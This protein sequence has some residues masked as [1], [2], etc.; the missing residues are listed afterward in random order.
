MDDLMAR[1]AWMEMDF[2]AIE[3]NLAVVRRCAGD[4]KAI[5]ASVKAN[6]YGHGV[7]E[8]AGRLVQSGVEVLATGSWSD[9]V[10]M[11]RAGLR[12]P[13]LMMG[14]ALPSA[15]PD[16][17]EW[18]LIPTVHNREL[19][20]AIK[21]NTRA[22]RR[23]YIK[24]DSG[25]GRLG[26]PLPD[27]H[28]FALQ[29]ARAPGLEIAGLYTHLPFFDAAGCKWARERLA[30]FD[31]LVAALARDGLEI[32]IT[33]SRASAALLA[34]LQGPMFGRISGRND[35]WSLPGRPRAG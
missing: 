23:I 11:R 24:V 4:G 1:P 32:P 30:Q 35:I 8:V 3:H 28:N 25:F 7:V 33:Q 15:I 31:A 16:M 27:A 2:S 26:V 13:I 10:R 19:A 17:L 12:A 29:L 14:G 20:D 34:G 21:D 22:K 9:A 5:I 6:A 18:D